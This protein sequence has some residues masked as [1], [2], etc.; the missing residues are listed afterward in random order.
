MLEP[1]V[2]LLD[3]PTNHLDLAGIEWLE[4]LLRSSSFA[5]VTVSHDRYFLEIDF[6]RDCRAESRVCRWIV[7]GE[8]HVQPVSGREAG[9]SRV[10]EPAAGEPAQPGAGRRS[11]GCGAGPR[12]GPPSPRRA[13]T[14]A[15][16]MIGQLAAMDSRT[17][18]NTAGIDFEA[19]QRKTKRL[20]EFEKRG[21]RRC[22]LPSGSRRRKRQSAHGA[23][24][25]RAQLCSHGGHEGG[26]GGAERQRQNDAA[27]PAARRDRAGRGDHQARRGAADGLLQPDARAGREPDA[28][29]RA[30]AGGRR[31]SSTRGARC[32]WPVG[33]RGFCLPASN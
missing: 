33:R 20:V 10:A 1:E 4:E 23:V 2:M 24:V 5:A 31:R 22:R 9:V 7:S 29:A 3:E 13:S 18:V 21:L 15:N 12:R 30:G 14:T 11:S 19:S 32:T 25:Y 6:E 16:A 28:A 8:G 27:A 17:V 26:A